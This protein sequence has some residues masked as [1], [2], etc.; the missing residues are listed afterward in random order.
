MAGA[1]G[2]LVNL[3]SLDL[4]STW[5]VELAVPSLCKLCVVVV[6]VWRVWLMCK[7]VG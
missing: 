5:H 1:L 6:L 3:T 2:K 7:G 4:A